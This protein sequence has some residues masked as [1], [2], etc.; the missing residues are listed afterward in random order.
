MSDKA[1]IYYHDIGDYLSRDEKLMIIKNFGNI[2]NIPWQTLRPN[3]HGDWINHRN[4]IFDTYIPLAPEKKGDLSAKSFFIIN[5]TGIMSA[6]DIWV[7]SFSISTLKN[8][9]NRM[10]CFYNQQMQSFVDTNNT[11]KSTTIDAYLNTDPT[12]ISWTRALRNDV[13]KQVTHTFNFENCRIGFYRPFC[14]Q[15]IYFGKGFIE[16]PSYAQKLFPSI[17]HKN[18]AICISG[19]GSNKD[20]SVLITDLIPDYQIQFNTQY[21]PLYY[22][23]EI[24]RQNLSLFDSSNDNYIRH[25]AISDFILERCRVAYGQRVCK[26]DIFYYVYGILHSPDYRMRFASDLKKR[27]PRL[28]LIDEPRDFWAFSKAGRALA[29]LHVN[30]ETIDPATNVNII[31]AA[32]ND[33]DYRVERMRFAK[34]GKDIDKSKI[35]YNHQIT[36]ENIPTEAYNYIVNGKSAIEWIMERYAITTHKESG[37]TNNPNDWATEHNNPQY[38]L[39]LLLRIIHLSLESVNIINELPKLKFE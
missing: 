8:N 38:I 17:K 37:I 31:Y 13:K 5:A 1:K 35:I 36:I 33:I 25:D 30:Y 14:K 18:L 34:S 9:M 23:E 11:N 12:Q 7:Y 29:E 10:I 6:R 3:N 27:L 32:G 19:I 20:L 2:N 15:R 26:E 16:S 21:F 39:N 4:D 28:P 22:Y 24:N